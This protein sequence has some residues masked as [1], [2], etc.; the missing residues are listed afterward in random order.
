M[1]GCDSRESQYFRV[2][3][4]KG[5]SWMIFRHEWSLLHQCCCWRD[6][7]Q[8]KRGF[9]RFS[10]KAVWWPLLLTL[11]WGG[12][13][14][15]ENTRASLERSLSQRIHEQSD[16]GHCRPT[17]HAAVSKRSRSKRG[18][19]QEHATARRWAQKSANASLRPQKGTKR[20][21]TALLRKIANNQVSSNQVWELPFQ[22]TKFGELPTHGISF[23]KSA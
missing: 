4:G 9:T 8:Q 7:F 10:L 13:V 1:Q 14:S 3:V 17:Q 5:L 22:T 12:G 23:A 2:A 21:K 16:D 20:R 15:M 6:K 11:A 18:R 19:T